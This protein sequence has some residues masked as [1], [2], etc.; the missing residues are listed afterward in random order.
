M[1]QND[2]VDPLLSRR[3]LLCAGGLFVPAFWPVDASAVDSVGR[4]TEVRGTVSAQGSGG[5]RTLDAASQIFLQDL[6]QTSAAARAALVMGSRTIVRL[7]ENV[8][9]RIDQYTIDRGGILELGAGAA[10]IDTRGSQPMG[11][12]VRSPS[13][14]IAV[15]GTA[16]FAGTEP[17][18]VFGVFVRSGTVDVTAASQ[19]VRLKPGQ[20]TTIAS[21][22]LPPEPAKTWGAERINRAMALTR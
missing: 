8:R 5:F 19:V 3:A 13:A 9:F 12:V 10:F 1:D 22:G 15:R 16:F 20:G 4:M 18:G 7:G 21:P 11:L 2:V 14:L 17:N 6:V